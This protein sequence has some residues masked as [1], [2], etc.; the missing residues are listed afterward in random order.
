MCSLKGEKFGWVLQKCTELGVVRFVPVVSQR[1]IVR[2]ASALEAKRERWQAV[3]R[4]A[5]EQSHRALLPALTPALDFAQ[6]IAQP[7]GT[8]LLPWEGAAA[9]AAAGPRRR[10]LV[11][12]PRSTCWL[13]PKAALTKLRWR[14]RRRQAGR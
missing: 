14:R 4:E 9:A 13:A 6:A 3:I 7:Q 2:P 10:R 1:S 12:L 5:A 8:R 11:A